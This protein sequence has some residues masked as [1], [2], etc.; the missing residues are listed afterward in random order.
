MINI[1]KHQLNLNENKYKKQRLLI[2]KI[3]IILGFKQSY[4]LKKIKESILF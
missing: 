3:S 2:A 1:T 4:Q